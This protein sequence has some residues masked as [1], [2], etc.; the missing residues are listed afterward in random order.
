MLFFFLLGFY[1]GNRPVSKLAD[2]AISLVVCLGGD[3]ALVPDIE[4]SSIL[5]DINGGYRRAMSI[6]VRDIHRLAMCTVGG[7]DV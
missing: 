3:G 1:N 2:Y 7:A 6:Q 5:V 4:E